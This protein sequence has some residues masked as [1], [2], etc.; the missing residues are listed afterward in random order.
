MI[1]KIPFAVVSKAVCKVAFRPSVAPRLSLNQFIGARYFSSTEKPVE[2]KVEAPEKEAEPV[3]EDPLEALK[4]QNSTLKDEVRTLK[5]KLLRSYAEEENVRRIAQRDVSA[6]KDYANTKF[7]KSLLEVADN[8]ERAVDAIDQEQRANADPH[9]MN[10][11]Q[12]V[13]MTQKGLQKVFESH[14][15]IRVSLLL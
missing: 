3:I 15:I 14:G 4:H 9:F 1:R 7:A 2:S 11:L 13:E 5:D 10:L 12:G 8:L 6:A